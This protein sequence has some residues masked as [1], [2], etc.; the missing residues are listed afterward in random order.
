MG[1]VQLPKLSNTHLFT[2]AVNA[3]LLGRYNRNLLF[4][5]FNYLYTA[6]DTCYKMTIDQKENTEKRASSHAQRIEWMCDK[7]K[8]TVPSW[9]KPIPCGENKVKTELSVIRNDLIHEGSFFNAPLGF[10][11]KDWKKHI[12]FMS[13]VAYE[14]GNLVCR[15]LV[16]LVGGK[17]KSYFERPVSNRQKTRLKLRQ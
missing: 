16:A 2:A 1:N 14:M 15:L 13:T 11:S 12:N 17:D 5:Q 7:H 4:E 10:V 8:V 6:I 3:L 9:A